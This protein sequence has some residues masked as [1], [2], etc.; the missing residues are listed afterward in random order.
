MPDVKETTTGKN[1]A[2]KSCD[3]A[4]KSGVQKQKPWTK[5][6]DLDA[7]ADPSKIN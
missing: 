4:K 5:V 2:G 7:K 6:S 1:K 3:K